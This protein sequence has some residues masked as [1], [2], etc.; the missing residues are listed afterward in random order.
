MTLM[1]RTL[2]VG[3]GIML[4]VALVFTGYLIVSSLGA[5]ADSV[6]L[7]VRPTQVSSAASTP[8]ANA[9]DRKGR[10]DGRHSKGSDDSTPAA[11]P[12]ASPSDDHGGSSGSGGSGDSGK[13]GGSGG[14]GGSDDSGKSPGG[15]SDDGSSHDGGG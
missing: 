4:P 2:L 11:T 10:D 15:G 8:S 13:S 1:K 3:A 14:S 6:P 9:E 12:S 5:S 7:P